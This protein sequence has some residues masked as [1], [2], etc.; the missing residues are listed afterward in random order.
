MFREGT[1]EIIGLESQPS[2]RGLLG[3]ADYAIPAAFRAD[4]TGPAG[5]VVPL[6]TAGGRIQ[7]QQGIPFGLWDGGLYDRAVIG[8]AQQN[9]T[10]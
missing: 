10:A 3:I 6:V 7:G 4:G 9:K 5:I 2:D 1:A 8:Q